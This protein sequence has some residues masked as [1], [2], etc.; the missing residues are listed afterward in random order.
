MIP[1]ADLLTLLL[2]LFIVLYGMSSTDAKKFEDMS[3]AFSVALNG[4]SGVLDHSSIDGSTKNTPQENEIDPSSSKN[5]SKSRSQLVRQEQIDLEKLKQRMDQYIKSNG[6]SAQLN[7]KLNQS[8][9]TITISD[10]ALFASG[11][12]VVKPES[13]QLGIAISKMLE[14]FPDY[15]IVVSGHTD[16]IPIDNYQFSSNWD[17]SSSRALNFMKI[18]LSDGKLDPRK[19]VNT[20]FGEYHPIAPNDTE[21]GRAKNRRVEVSVIR[22]YQNETAA[23]TVS[24]AK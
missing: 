12:A 4:G 9:L 17:L 7:T 8:Q 14:S 15:D 19:F 11:L 3:K 24:V 2:A 6:L 10:Q 23:Q 5:I 1:Y 22:K 20:G 16:N 13:Q 18:L 21:A